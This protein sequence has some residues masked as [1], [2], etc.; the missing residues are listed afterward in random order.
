MGDRSPPLVEDFR[1]LL[2]TFADC[3]VEFGL[4]GD[5]ALALRRYGYR[6]LHAAADYWMFIERTSQ[7]LSLHSVHVSPTKKPLP[8]AV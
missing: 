8:V 1:D 4:I 2:V 3:E 7:P 6:V 5:W